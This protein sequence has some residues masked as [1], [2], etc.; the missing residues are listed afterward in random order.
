MGKWV[1]KVVL[2]VQRRK[3]FKV[4]L[5]RYNICGELEKALGGTCTF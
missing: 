2:R 5:R 1:V 4:L 3:K